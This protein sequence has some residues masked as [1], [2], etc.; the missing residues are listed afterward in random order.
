VAAFSLYIHLAPR[1]GYSRWCVAW[2]PVMGVITI[3]LI[4]Q[5]TIRT[6]IQGGIVWRGTFYGLPEIRA[7]RKR[8]RA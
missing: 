6:W 8:L 7:G 4:W 3:A 2:L 1:F 5:I